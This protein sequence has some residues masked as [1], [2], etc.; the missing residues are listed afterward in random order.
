MEEAIRLKERLAHLGEMAAGI[1]HEI[2]NP[3]ASLTGS[4][5]VL[6]EELELRDHQEKL[7]AIALKEA[8]RLNHLI[9]DF[10]N[11]AR[12]RNPESRSVELRSFLE[13]EIFFFRNSGICPPSI[14]IELVMDPEL[15]YVRFDPN[16]MKQVFWNLF[17]NA[18]EAMP[19]GGDIRVSAGME[20]GY[21][22]RPS[23]FLLVEDTGTGIEAEVLPRIFNPFYSTK[24]HGTG[25]GLSIVH[26]IVEEHGGKITASGSPGGGAVFRI[27]LPLNSEHLLHAEDQ[28]RESLIG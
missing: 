22:E 3:L 4:M 13:E 2:R 20:T 1:A 16:L 8:D 19:E 7:M 15:T 18:G 17:I 28:K 23:W 9:S 14:R 27:R 21:A 26:R 10:L 6:K 5:E 12:P 25:L 24:D 11:Y